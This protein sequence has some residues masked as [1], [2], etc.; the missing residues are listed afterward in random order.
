MTDETK[1]QE[2]NTVLGGQNERLVIFAECF[3]CG[4][5]IAK[6]S[7]VGLGVC[8]GG[9]P[10][11]MCRKCNEECGDFVFRRSLQVMMDNK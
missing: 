3:N 7:D 1:E 9:E 11:Y 5:A 8:R 2:A 6:E 4:G 10:E